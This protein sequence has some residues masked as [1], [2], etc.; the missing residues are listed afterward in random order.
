M[1][2]LVE[3]NDARV[4]F[5]GI[6]AV[7]GVSLS[8]E[9]GRLYGLVGP[10]GS[11]KST[12][13]GVLSR[14]TDLTSGTL[15]FDGH[16]Y[17]KLSPQRVA[18]MGL[19]RTFQTVRLLPTLSVRENVMMGAD[20]RTYGH[21]ILPN[22]VMPRRTR[23]C[24]QFC[25]AAADSAIDRLELG[26]FAKHTPS[27]LSYGVQRRVE[28][29]RVLAAAP[30]IIFFDEPTAGM[31]REERDEIGSIMDQLRREGLTQVLVEHDM[32]MITDVCDH[33]Y[34]MNLGKLIAEGDAVSVVQNP[35]VQ[36][37]YLGKSGRDHNVA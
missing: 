18:R 21:R 10:N 3:V 27:E 30:R 28:I 23:R 6:K 14:L 26:R 8:L 1:S 7:D 24:E 25:R 4:H 11:G 34:V 9:E 15:H 33:V 32:Q 36:A 2:I 29:A 37:A 5:G 16:E 17:E 20:V 22:W 13:I 35:E 31:N 19:G 12:L